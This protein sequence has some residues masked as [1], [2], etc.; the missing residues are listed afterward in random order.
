MNTPDE[1]RRVLAWKLHWYRQSELE[2]ALLLGRM[3]GLC[4]DGELS[5]SL[6]RHCADEARHSFLWSETIACLDLPMVRIHRSYQSFYLDEGG[7]PS[8]LVNTLAFTQIF[9]RRVHRQFLAELRDPETPPTARL[10]FQTMLKDEKDHLHWVAEWLSGQPDSAKA[11][12]RYEGIDAVVYKKLHPYQGK[13]WQ[14][15]NLGSELAPTSNT[16]PTPK[17]ERTRSHASIINS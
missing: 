6:T 3:V 1:Q 11:L 12:A 17:L 14:I 5:R 4:A 16:H 15:P 10:V 7:L 13:L 8:N 2:G 9:E